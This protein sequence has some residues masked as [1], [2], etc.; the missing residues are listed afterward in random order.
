M[1]H[2]GIQQSSSHSP[3][4]DKSPS[5]AVRPLTTQTSSNPQRP[6]TQEEIENEVFDQNRFEAFGLQL[7]DE[8]GTIT[9]DEVARLGVLQAQMNDFWVQRLS[10]TAPAH[11]SF[12]NIPVHAPEPS[13]K[14]SDPGHQLTTDSRRTIQGQDGKTTAD[15]AAAKVPHADD[16]TLPDSLK[17]GVRSLSGV[18]LDD[19]QVHYNSTQPAQLNALAFAQASDIHVAPGQEKHL[20]HEAWHVV[21]QKK[22]RVR[23]T[24]QLRGLPV[25]DDAELE[26]DAD[27]MGQRAA[28]VGSE[29]DRSLEPTTAD[30]SRQPA[31]AAASIGSGSLPATIQAAGLK[32]LLKKP[33]P[34]LP[35]EVDIVPDTEIKATDEYKLLTA[36]EPDG[37]GLSEELALAAARLLLR[38]L[39]ESKNQEEV[40]DSQWIDEAVARAGQQLAVEGKDKRPVFRLDRGHQRQYLAAVERARERLELLRTIMRDPQQAAVV[41]GELWDLLAGIPFKF[42]RVNLEAAL[43]NNKLVRFI[44]KMGFANL[45]REVRTP[46]GFQLL[47]ETGQLATLTAE[48]V[49]ELEPVLTVFLMQQMQTPY[50]DESG[51]PVSDYRELETSVLNRKIEIARIKSA[52]MSAAEI[53]GLQQKLQA[54][55]G[56]L[57]AERER[58]IKEQRLLSQDIEADERLE[59]NRLRARDEIDEIEDPV[60]RAFQEYR[61]QNKDIPLSKKQAKLK[62]LRAMLKNPDPSANLDAIRTEVRLL[63]RDI[64]ATEAYEKSLPKDVMALWSRWTKLS[65]DMADR[66]TRARAINDE[67]RTLTQPQ[68]AAKA[69][70]EPAGTEKGAQ[71]KQKIPL[72]KKELAQIEQANQSDQVEL[73]K[74]KQLNPNLEFEAHRFQRQGTGPTKKRADLEAVQQQLGAIEPEYQYLH[75]LK[76]SGL[77]SAAGLEA[78]LREAIGRYQQVV[79]K[80]ERD[81]HT[82]AAKF[83]ATIKSLSEELGNLLPVRI[84]EL[85][86]KLA[87][88]LPK[89]DAAGETDHLILAYMRW[90]VYRR[91]AVEKQLVDAKAAED[92]T[93]AQTYRKLGQNQSSLKDVEP[94]KNATIDRAGE[95]VRNLKVRLAQVQGFA[96]RA[97]EVP[98]LEAALAPDL[99]LLSI[100]TQARGAVS[101][102]KLVKLQEY[103]E[104]FEARHIVPLLLEF[105]ADITA[106]K[107][108][109]EQ[110]LVLCNCSGWLSERTSSAMLLRLDK[111]LPAGFRS[112][113]KDLRNRAVHLFDTNMIQILEE[114]TIARAVAE[115]AAAFGIQLKLLIAQSKFLSGTVT[116]EPPR[117]ASGSQVFSAI[118]AAAQA[119]PRIQ[120]DFDVSGGPLPPSRSEQGSIFKT[121]VTASPL[122]IEE[123]KRLILGWGIGL[124]E[125]VA[126]FAEP[127]AGLLPPQARERRLQLE[128]RLQ[129][130]GQTI[131]NLQQLDETLTVLGELNLTVGQVAG[132]DLLQE[133]VAAVKEFRSAR[134]HG[135]FTNVPALQTSLMIILKQSAEIIRALQQL[136]VLVAR[137]TPFS[138]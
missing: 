1:T 14:D 85:E 41:L 5:L 3:T 81:A 25:N 131:G 122:I 87:G 123:I 59:R 94:T 109:P 105:E 62:E 19:V 23:P 46:T 137:K 128:S 83:G 77:D 20:P 33:K 93:I 130:L 132:F 40:I 34:L 67:I 111:V 6:P 36:K 116:E 97:G 28:Q 88:E 91:A 118:N 119:L 54:D 121:A 99:K 27:R 90:F 65:Q 68:P 8:S 22:G 30:T 61:L 60:E 79:D 102:V 48:V 17:T 133:F 55:Y 15:P 38:R 103:Q 115:A 69:D 78:I 13:S 112:A 12:A 126:L 129:A 43:P 57:A 71:P 10:A 86:A 89:F 124:H 73:D 39:Y 2:Q 113:L 16:T 104:S 58:L 114:P 52:G 101:T 75:S 106:A 9:P 50:F 127:S 24:R 51:E 76:T 18:D 4:Q 134:T 82:K 136:N 74:I 98:K 35:D 11:H 80:I 125:V 29:I 7:K 53:E 96:A 117:H 135:G 56:K 108:T 37:R 100:M 45:V 92:E 21:Q 120:L 31:R 138:D 32:D 72:L 64:E 70:K 63:K 47:C 44:T 66:Q 42:G 49:G 95:E 110:L 26:H 107:N 84:A